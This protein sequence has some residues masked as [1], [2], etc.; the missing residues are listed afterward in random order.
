MLRS[1]DSINRKE[2]NQV[3]ADHTEFQSE[4][5][6]PVKIIPQWWEIQI[7]RIIM[8]RTFKFQFKLQLNKKEESQRMQLKVIELFKKQWVDN[9]LTNSVVTI[10]RTILSNQE[11]DQTVQL[12]Q[13]TVFT[14]QEDPSVVLQDQVPEPEPMVKSPTPD[15]S[16]PWSSVHAN[17]ILKTSKTLEETSSK[18]TEVESNQFL[19]ALTTQPIVECAVNF[20]LSR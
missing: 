19:W 1:W 15:P 17:Q 2:F 18:Q 12:Q 14:A 3:R 11:T 8:H 20:M 4:I 16:S 9:K 6:T 5:L 10:P 13:W 7:Y